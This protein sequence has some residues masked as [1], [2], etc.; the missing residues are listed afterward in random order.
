MF[1][2]QSHSFA[3]LVFAVGLASQTIRV[4]AYDWTC[5]LFCYNKGVCRHGHGKFGAYAG[6]DSMTEEL[7]FE[8]ELHEN[9]MYCSC[10]EGYTGLQCEIKYV[11]CGRDDHTCFNGSACVKERASNDGKVFYRCECDVNGSVMDAPYA[12]KYC[13]HIATTF[14]DGGDGFTHGSSFC[15]NGGK[16]KEH[17]PNST[18]KHRGCICPDGWEGEHCETLI[19]KVSVSEFAQGLNKVLSG[20]DI[21]WI[22]IGAII[23]IFVIL[24]FRRYLRI[25]KQGKGS[26]RRDRRNQEMTSFNDTRDII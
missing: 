9:G 23:C 21:V 18:T 22:I 17:D 20:N 3:V 5:N 24:Y 19:N 15:T 26:N 10:P 7:P 12:G 14:C 16:C 6:I 1:G 25:K 13:E 11:T 4:D 2:H 8:K